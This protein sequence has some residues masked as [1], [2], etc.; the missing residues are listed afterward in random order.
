M[1]GADPPGVVT[2]TTHERTST[3]LLKRVRGS[4][5]HWGSCF[6]AAVDRGDRIVVMIQYLNRVRP[7]Q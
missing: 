6:V 5:N 1:T 2:V 3:R 4:Y 7:S